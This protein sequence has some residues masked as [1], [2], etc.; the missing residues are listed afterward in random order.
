MKT[1][2]RPVLRMM[3]WAVAVMLTTIRWWQDRHEDA[4]DYRLRESYA[5][6]WDASQSLRGIAEGRHQPMLRQSPSMA[7]PQVGVLGRRYSEELL[8]GVPIPL[9]PVD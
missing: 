5:H 1:M 6:L 9:K 3:R 2:P 4:S 7:L 8:E